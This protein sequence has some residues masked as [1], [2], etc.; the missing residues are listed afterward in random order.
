MHHSFIITSQHCL[1]AWRGCIL[2]ELDCGYRNCCSVYM[3]VVFNDAASSLEITA[4]NNTVLENND[5]ERMQQE[6][7]VDSSAIFLEG[8]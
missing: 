8:I 2:Q 3:C 6:V 4:I 5:L 7:T 1:N